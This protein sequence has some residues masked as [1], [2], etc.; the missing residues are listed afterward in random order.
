MT[1]SRVVV[2]LAVQSL[3]GGV[4][5]EPGQRLAVRHRVLGR[6]QV[7][8]GRRALQDAA[9]EQA[10]RVRTLRERGDRVRHAAEDVQA[11]LDASANNARG[12]AD[13]RRVSHRPP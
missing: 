1:C 5:Q 3:Q 7:Y 13:E 10:P 4:T 11:V 2:L 8:S 9:L 12:S 6:A